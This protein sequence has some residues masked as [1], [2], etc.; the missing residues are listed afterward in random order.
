MTEQGCLT[1]CEVLC[2]VI[3]SFYFPYEMDLLLK[4]FPVLLKH[5]HNVWMKIFFS[6]A[7]EITIVLGGVS[8]IWGTA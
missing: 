6:S 2:I 1:D 4:Q 5:P 3:K 8:I 7:P